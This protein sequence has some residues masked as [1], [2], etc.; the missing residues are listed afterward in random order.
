MKSGTPTYDLDRLQALV[1]PLIKNP[2]AF[3]WSIQG[4]GF[5]R[6]YLTSDRV[7]R[8]HIWDSRFRKENVSDI[9]THPWGLESTILCGRISNDRFR[10]AHDGV[11]MM[12]QLLR[13]GENAILKEKPE[14][15][16]LRLSRNDSMPPGTSYSQDY[17]EIH[18]TNYDNGTITVVRR[19]FRP[20]TEHAYTF[21]PK[22]QK[23][24]DA[25]PRKAKPGEVE[26]IT[27][28]AL[29]TLLTHQ[30]LRRSLREST[31]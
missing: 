19:I 10:I 20:D 13:T 24:V 9:H 22:G 30:E 1:I 28:K 25:K 21:W 5:L 14:P 18:R 15:I 8:L 6:H 11:P 31:R 23:W 2:S 12:R 17:D 4:F 26:Q 7:W 16:L 3:E 29:E 27:Q